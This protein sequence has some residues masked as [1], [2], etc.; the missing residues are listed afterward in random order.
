MKSC[1][2]SVIAASALPAQKFT[3]DRNTMET[4]GA[5]FI[6]STMAGKS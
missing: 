2:H 6:F 4:L 3:S 1:P 5:D